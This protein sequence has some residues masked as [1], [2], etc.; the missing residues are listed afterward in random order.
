MS[1]SRATA[2]PS[3]SVRVGSRARRAGNSAAEAATGAAG[4]AAAT[5]GLA[6]LSTARRDVRRRREARRRSRRLRRA[7]AQPSRIAARA[8]P[9]RMWRSPSHERW[10]SMTA[11]S[12]AG[13]RPRAAIASWSGPSPGSLRSVSPAARV[14]TVRARASF[15]LFSRC[16]RS[17]ILACSSVSRR[18]GVEVPAAPRAPA[19]RRVRRPAS[20]VRD[21]RRRTC[22]CPASRVAQSRGPASR[23]LALRSCTRARARGVGHLVVHRQ[24]GQ[25]SEVSAAHDRRSLHRRRPRARARRASR[26]AR[27]SPPG[28]TPASPKDG[29]RFLRTPW[30]GVVLGSNLGRLPGPHPR[31]AARGGVRTVAF[32]RS[33]RRKN[34]A[35]RC[36][37]TSVRVRRPRATRRRSARSAAAASAAAAAAAARGARAAAR[38]RRRNPVTG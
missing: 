24:D 34:C 28:Q 11:C 38:E 19:R 21:V 10:G 25:P 1:C 20:D 2:A 31:G 4:R 35:V 26:P 15:L 36:A 17:P 30:I 22:R 5:R 6:R 12:L 27:V 16:G 13:A 9:G 18:R 37:A 14:G 32:V 7:A 29:A 3:L 23:A 8:E 33:R